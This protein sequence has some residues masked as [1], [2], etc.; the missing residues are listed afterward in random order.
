MTEESAAIC[1]REG[2][3][4]IGNGGEQVFQ[5]SRRLPAQMRFEFC[6]G[7][8]DGVE[9]GAVRRQVAK[10]DTLGLE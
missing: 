5:G 7:Q 3:Q 9:V 8:F 2:V 6:K 10:R 1:V 4:G